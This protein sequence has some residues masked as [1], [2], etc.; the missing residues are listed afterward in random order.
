MNSGRGGAGFYG[1][2]NSPPGDGGI[3][4]SACGDEVARAFINGG[5]GGPS[6]P[7]HGPGG[8]GGGGCGGNYGGGGGGGYSGGG[9]GSSN[10]WG[11]GG[12]G[13]IS[14]GYDSTI[15]GDMRSGDGYLNIT[16]WD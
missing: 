2:G 15:T 14:T 6:G 10:G 7:H 9:G 1:D 16:V 8:F 13:S 4:C 5:A 3:Y 12:G 11:G